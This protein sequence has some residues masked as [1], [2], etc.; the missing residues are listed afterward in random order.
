MVSEFFIANESF[1]CSDFIQREKFKARRTARQAIGTVFQNREL[2]RHI[3]ILCSVTTQPNLQDTKLFILPFNHSLI[4]FC[5]HFSEIFERK[6]FL[7]IKHFTDNIYSCTTQENKTHV[8]FLLFQMLQRIFLRGKDMVLM[9]K[10][11]SL[12]RDTG[13]LSSYNL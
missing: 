1:M 10:E 6:G 5:I 11:N 2:R 8:N 7:S 12:S 3:G 13:K 4:F 9:L